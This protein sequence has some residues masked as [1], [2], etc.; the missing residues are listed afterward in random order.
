MF[1][2]IEAI[3]N[4]A[5]EEAQ[6]LSS[7]SLGMLI[8]NVWEGKVKPRMARIDD[9]SKLT[10]YFNLR[11][12]PINRL[13]KSNI[14]INELTPQTIED[15]TTLCAD[16]PG[17]IVDL[18]L[19]NKKSI[20]LMRPPNPDRCK[21]VAINGYRLTMEIEINMV[22]RPVITM[23]TCG[24]QVSFADIIGKETTEIT[25]RTVD[26]A[27]CLLEYTTPCIG[28]T[29]EDE[30]QF[31]KLEVAN[32]RVVTVTFNSEE[33]RKHLMSTSCLLIQFRGN[34]CKSCSYTAKL[35]RNRS[36]KRRSTT[37][38]FEFPHKK[39]NLRFFNNEGLEKKI[40]IKRKQLNS[41]M[42]KE[43][44]MKE[45]EMIELVDEDSCDLIEIVKSSNIKDVPPNLR[46]LW[47]QQMEQLSKQSS[48]GYRWDP[49]CFCID[50]YKLILYE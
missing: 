22:Q 16:R 18:S 11:K 36:S 21:A 24:K 30:D 42:K 13:H 45:T 33:Q 48:N 38:Q 34:V 46:L 40:F 32:S 25:L 41:D 14:I 3:L 39:C 35:F 15:I 44:R 31:F 20:R 23:S 4:C 1:V 28:K 49:R 12:R 17:W 9:V 26:D 50:C 43:S 5:A 2:P 7:G 8:R 6:H 10:G 47:E 37:N 27:I 19:V 29:I